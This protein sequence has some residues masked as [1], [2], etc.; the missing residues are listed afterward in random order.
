MSRSLL[1]AVSLSALLTGVTLFSRPLLP[2]DETR[3][4]SVAW[5]AYESGDYLVPHLNGDTYAHKPPV[6]F[7]LINLVWQATGVSISAARWVVPAGGM[8][9]LW[10]TWLLARRLWPQSPETADCAPL[11]LVSSMLWMVM[12][13]LTMFDTLLT[14]FSLAS[15]LGVVQAA[16]GRFWIG[17]M[18][19]GLAMGLGIL[20]KGPVI[21]VHVLPAALAAPWWAPPA[22]RFWI[23][24]YAGLMCCML[25]AATVG[26]SWALPAATAGGEAYAS[27]LLYGQTAGRMVQS[28]AHK[29]A[30]W[31]YLP[32]V[33]V[34]LLP[35]L[36]FVPLW[37][38]IFSFRPDG[39]LKFSA[40]AGLS[41]LLIM[42]LVSGKQIHYLVPMLPHCAMA[43]SRL[44]SMRADTKVE[45]RDQLLPAAATVLLGMTPVIINWQHPS[46]SEAVAGLVSSVY[47][48][49][50][51]LFGVAVAII[52]AGTVLRAVTVISTF[53]IAFLSVIVFA[54]SSTMWDGFD[55]EPL[56][57]FVHQTR[58]PICWFK[59]YHG[60]INL[61]G[62]ISRVTEVSSED[63]LQHWLEDAPEGVVVMRLSHSD[64]AWVDVLPMMQEIDRT[65]P[66][67]EQQQ[68]LIVAL[69]SIDRFPLRKQLRQI[70]YVQWIRSGLYSSPH[71][72][73]KY[74]PAVE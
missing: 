58:Q 46:G 60:Q 40:V 15:L 48:I 68:A 67:A 32:W 73:L 38:G 8:G 14:F 44:A 16:Q 5:H 9:C 2:V 57:R 17:W 49:P 34:C 41:T 69:S 39:G 31:W 18:T 61:I 54:L 6:L 11:I 74:A 22:R 53:S 30:I 55:L 72:V 66:T 3:Y 47:S 19:A 21:L 62:R 50:L 13:P 10:L 70:V 27:E 63:D 26:L 25:L 20:T 51:V 65:S 42:S 71:L 56:A 52:P 29:E 36:N 4:L 24:W 12:L 59:G 43:I 7:W 1:W 45:R 28:F 35:W 64:P 37:R 33:P 23:K